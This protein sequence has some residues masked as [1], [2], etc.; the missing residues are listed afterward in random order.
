MLRSERL[1]VGFW[2]ARRIV[3]LAALAGVCAAQ[4]LDPVKWSLKVDTP[5]AAAGSQIP[6]HLIA[7]IEP[8]WHLYSLSTPPPSRPTRLQLADNTVFEKFTTYYQHPK[9]AFDPN[10]NIETQTYEEKADFLLVTTVKK[11]APAGPADLIAEIRFNVCD[12]TRCLPPRK[13]TA[14]ASLKI[15]PGA[16][17]AAI[18]IPAGFSEF[19]PGAPAAAAPVEAPKSES[20]SQAQQSQDLGPFLLLAFGGGLLAIFTPCVF[21]MIPITMSFFLNRPS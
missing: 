1:A 13:R 6:A 5:A 12:A 18:A 7:T 21:P 10:F 11:D 19:K 15:D 4:A 9:R 14:T 17:G 8:G 16:S 3:L 2:L 20:Q